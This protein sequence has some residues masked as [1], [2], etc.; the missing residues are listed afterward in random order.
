[1]KV[2]VLTPGVFD[3]GGISRYGRFQ[4]R[5]LRAAFGDASVQVMS[6]VGRRAD[7]L[8]QPL[9]VEWCGPLPLT[10]ASRAYFSGAALQ[11]ALTFRPDVVLCALVNFGPLAWAVARAC[12]AR[13]VQNLYGLEIWS[14]LAWHRRAA[15]GAADA[16]IADCHNSAD[17]AVAR[18]LVRVRPAVVWDCVELERYT[19]G[20]A[21]PE[22]L[23]RY[24]LEARPRRLRVL[25]LGRLE[26]NARYK[27]PARL[28][29]LLADLPAQRFEAVIAG[30][31]DDLEHLRGLASELALGERVQI[32][33]AIHEADLP[34][35]YRSADAFYL[36][37]EVG[38]HQGEGIPLTPLEALACGVP[39]IVG[40]QDGSREVLD[41]AAG[42]CCDPLDLPRQKA[43]LQRLADDPTFHDR[44]RRA[45]RARA[46]AAF[47][48]PA[49]AEKTAAALRAVGR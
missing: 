44:E 18:K 49:F 48:Y 16:V 45:A 21:A 19:A 40:D 17:Q 27:G 28:L 43:Y 39:V 14:D 7:D 29:R 10:R 8:E 31:G 36:A 42:L 15:L 47:G 41:G 24:G 35:L 11:R 26:R 30:K 4:I 38:P 9:A 37:S 12:G 6:L 20:P 5:A 2:L 3:K 34:D 33:G 46:E 32:P 1:M 23:A 25:F 13:L 22:A